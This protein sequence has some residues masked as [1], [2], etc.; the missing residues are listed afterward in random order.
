MNRKKEKLRMILADD[1]SEE[2]VIFRKIL[3]SLEFMEVELLS[4]HSALELEDFLAVPGQTPPHIIFLDMH[5]PGKNG[6]ECLKGIRS[7]D[8]YKHIPIAMYSMSAD[9]TVIGNCLGAG[10]N[11]FITKPRELKALKDTLREVLKS[12]MQYHSM[13]LNFETFVRAF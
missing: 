6:M 7:N 11:I 8:K 13:S 10:A 3:Q 5:M 4:C 2:H 1:L 9:E 12:C